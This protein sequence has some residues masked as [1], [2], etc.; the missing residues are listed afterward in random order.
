MIKCNQCGATNREDIK[1]CLTCGADHQPKRNISK[2]QLHFN[3][4]FEQA[5]N[6]PNQIRDYFFKTLR[7][8][9]E[10]ELDPKGYRQYF[11]HFHSSGF[12]KKFDIKAQQ[13]AEK[14]LMINNQ[15]GLSKEQNI[16]KL[17][18]QTLEAFIDYFIIV[19][20]EPLHKL[21]LPEAILRYE[22]IQTKE[23]N[24][25]KMIL[26]YLD[27]ENKNEKV[28]TDFL[29]FSP[30][31]MSNAKE[32]FL[33]AEKGE[34]LFFICDQTVFGSCK[35]GFAMTDSAIYWKAHFNESGKVNYSE[36]NN[37]KR[38]GEWLLINEQ[39]FNVSKEMNYKMMKLLQKI[40]VLFKP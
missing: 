7:Y 3:L 19:C 10:N 28:Y 33:F 13:L 25:E 2:D 5:E 22:K 16:D 11:D 36:L 23:L 32:T 6:L 4:D 35:E 27:F 18:N 30:I 39:F 17:L 9:I 29:R 31:K 20:C 37:I 34:D 12:Y 38:D 21:K 8:R 15:N 14:I 26:D 40:R 1:I 24:L